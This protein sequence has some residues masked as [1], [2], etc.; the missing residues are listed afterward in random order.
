VEI[1]IGL[2]VAVVMLAV[3]ASLYGVAGDRAPYALNFLAVVAAAVLAGWRSGLIALVVGQALVWNL[4]VTPSSVSSVPSDRISAAIIATASQ[5]LILLVIGLYQREVDKGTAEREQ[6]LALLDEALRE[7]DHRT[8]NNYQT[9]LAMIDLQARRSSDPAVAE[10]LSQVGDRIQAIANA[11]QQLAV[12]SADL[13]GVR[14][15]DHL[16]GLVKQ[17]ER[18]LSRSGIEIDCEVDE[19]T[20]SVEKATSISI[21]V[22]ELVTNAIKHAFNGERSGRVLVRGRTGGSFELI[23]TDDGRGMEAT[24]KDDHMGL[25]TKL[26]ES[27]ARQLDAKHDVTSSEKGTTHRLEI[28]SLD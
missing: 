16:C 17:I 13:A 3:R 15:D 10:A 5:A 12:R 27:F 25:G 9:V 4:I 7:I 1:A 2:G 22:N 23:V 28:P 21:I 6:R 14:L 20:A 8:R 26:I 18:G 11:S 19:A 24:R